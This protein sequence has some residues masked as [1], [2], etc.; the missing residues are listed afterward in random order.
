MKERVPRMIEESPHD[1]LVYHGNMKHK[2]HGLKVDN[3]D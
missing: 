3:K 1:I 2:M